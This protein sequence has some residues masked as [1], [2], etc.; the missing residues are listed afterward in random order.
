MA[1]TN[2]NKILHSQKLKRRGHTHKIKG[3]PAILAPPKKERNK[4]ENTEL[5]GTWVLKGN[6]Y[7]YFSII[8]LNVN[9]LNAPNKR[10]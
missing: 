9:G 4:G 7:I 10:H 1:T 3:N 8:T 6:K 5:T 2:Q